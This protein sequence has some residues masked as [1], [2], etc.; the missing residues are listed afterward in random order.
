MNQSMKL[1]LM[2]SIAIVVLSVGAARAEASD[3]IRARVPF[4]FVVHNKT[5]PAG[6][7]LLLREDTDP[8]V[9]LIQEVGKPH[10][11]AFVVTN[12]AA[13]RDPAG[14]KPCLTFTRVENQYRLSNVWESRNE[15][16]TVV[17]KQ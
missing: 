10:A 8:A 7:Y 14:D 4:P 11:A 1:L 15:G 9:L 12:G 16:R 3:T 2:F 13:G 17:G 5:L 6:Q